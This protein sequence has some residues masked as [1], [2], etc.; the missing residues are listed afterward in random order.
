MF[1][2]NSEKL[3]S[4]SE[5]KRRAFFLICNL[6][7]KCC[8]GHKKRSFDNSARKLWLKTWKISTW[9]LKKVRKSFLHS[10]IVFHEDV[11]MDTYNHFW[12]TCTKLVGQLSEQILL[13]VRKLLFKMSFFNRRFFS[14]KRYSRNK[15]CKFNKTDKISRRTSGLI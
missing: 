2:L 3:L 11:F 5:G 12:K 6:S 8:P 1:H 9:K 4:M 10:S 13:E 7:M 15:K 14:P